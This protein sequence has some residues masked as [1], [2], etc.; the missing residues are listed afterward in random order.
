MS[1]IT[2]YRNRVDM[3]IFSADARGAIGQNGSL[4]YRNAKDMTFF[5]EKTE[6]AFL[7]MGSQT[8][9]SLPFPKLLTER[10]NIGIILTREPEKF[11]HRLP[12]RYFAMTEE[13][14]LDPVAFISV[15]LS[16]EDMD[17][18][19]VLSAFLNKKIIM[20]GGAYLYNQME[21]YGVRRVYLTK[22]K[23]ADATK[24]D[25]FVNLKQ[26]IFKRRPRILYRDREIDILE[27]AM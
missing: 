17:Y 1:E 27:Y 26:S 21:K 2:F 11:K 7:I 18:D 14:F 6:N 24:G 8:F 5:K 13:A 10:N 9:Y 19:E 4:L 15:L 25:T 20:I 16:K 22:F 12:P 23:K 3:A